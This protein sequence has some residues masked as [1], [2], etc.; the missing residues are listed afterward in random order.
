MPTTNSTSTHIPKC[1]ALRNQSKCG[2]L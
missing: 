1:R 2:R